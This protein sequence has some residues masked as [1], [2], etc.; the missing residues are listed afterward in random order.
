MLHRVL[1][2]L[3]GHWLI[4]HITSGLEKVDKVGLIYN[5]VLTCQITKHDFLCISVND[6]DLKTS[7]N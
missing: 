5:T 3:T 4:C 7:I 1:D 2:D 6:I